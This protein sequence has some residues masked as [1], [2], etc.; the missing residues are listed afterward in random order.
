MLQNIHK[1]ST[2][3][4]RNLDSK[5][6]HYFPVYMAKA[7]EVFNKTSISTKSRT[8]MIVQKAKDLAEGAVI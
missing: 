6:K 8:K 5:I 7:E 1:L 3:M 4:M 2:G